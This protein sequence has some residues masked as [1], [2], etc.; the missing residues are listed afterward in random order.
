MR[1]G[2]HFGLSAGQNVGG[3][4]VVS[5]DFVGTRIERKDAEAG[6]VLVEGQDRAN[7]VAFGLQTLC[8]RNMCG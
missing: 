5:L 6:Y 7:L 3:G 2:I 4:S 8:E 1:V